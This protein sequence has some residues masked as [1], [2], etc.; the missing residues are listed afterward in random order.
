M[1]SFDFSALSPIERIELADLLY[2][3]AMR[4]IEAAQLP[5]EQLAELD[6][7]IADMQSG[8][9]EMLPW[10]AS[11]PMTPLTRP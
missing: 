9:V 8:K 11:W 6:R 3:S 10:E 1:T 4:Q 7:R 2:D 5:P